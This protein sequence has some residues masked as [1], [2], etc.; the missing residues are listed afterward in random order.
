LASTGTEGRAIDWRGWFALGWAGW[1][2][3]LYA[4]T[5]LVERAPGLLRAIGRII[6]P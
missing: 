4:R 6:H 3:V 2:G 1:F 5:I